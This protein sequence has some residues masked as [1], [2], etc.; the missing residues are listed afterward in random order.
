M[1]NLK[2]VSAEFPLGTFTAVTGVSG[3]GKSSL[4]VSTLQRALERKLNK[5]RVVPGTHDQIAGLEHVDKVVVIDQSAIGRSPK[6]NP[7]TYTGVMDGIRNV[8]AQM[9]EAKQRGYGAGRFSFNV[10]SGRCAACEG[11]GL[12]HI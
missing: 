6:S 7:A 1:N 12:N 11:R 9:P 10:A 5:A 2:Q 4:V 3:S 8:L